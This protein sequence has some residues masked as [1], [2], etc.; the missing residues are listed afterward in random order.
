MM[1]DM[2][3]EYKTTRTAYN[4]TAGTTFDVR[5]TTASKHSRE[6]V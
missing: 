6:H 2:G 1:A 3:Q 4:A 5:F